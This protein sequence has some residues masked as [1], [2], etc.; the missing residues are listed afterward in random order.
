MTKEA[1]PEVLLLG[2]TPDHARLRPHREVPAPAAAAEPDDKIGALRDLMLPR[3]VLGLRA[4]RRHHAA[5]DV[6]LRHVGE[7]C[8]TLGGFVARLHLSAHRAHVVLYN[9]SMPPF[10][11]LRG[12][13]FGSLTVVNRVGTTGYGQPI[14]LCICACGA[15]TSVFGNSLRTGMTK[16]CGCLQRQAVTT[17]GMTGSPEFTVWQMMIQRCTNPRARGYARYGGRGIRVC[18]R[19]SGSFEAFLADVGPRPS[20]AYSLDRYPDND[21]HYEPG[22][23]RWATREQQ[24]ANSARARL[25]TFQGETLPLRAWCR[26][27]N[28]PHSTVMNRL[29]WGWSVDHAL[30]RPQAIHVRRG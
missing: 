22:N 30:S 14:W 7:A 26:R 28:I 1:G 15:N 8:D 21:G 23:V 6:K 20:L 12:R 10:I 4:A 11:D 3:Q 16:S 17:H 13:R 25:L 18:A 5:L 29:K 27:V 19:W 9:I 2:F 24:Q